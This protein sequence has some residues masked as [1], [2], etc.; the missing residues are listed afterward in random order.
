MFEVW[1]EIGPKA[2]WN[3]DRATIKAAPSA[4]KI[5]EQVLFIYV[6]ILDVLR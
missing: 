4:I 6:N 3:G 1:E 2:I 5:M